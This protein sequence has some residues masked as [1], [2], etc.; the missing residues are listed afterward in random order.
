[1]SVTNEGAFSGTKI[2]INLTPKEIKALVK[3]ESSILNAARNYLI[4][5]GFTEVIVPHITKATGACENPNS[6]FEVDYFNEKIKPY[7][8]QTGQ[9]YLEIVVPILEKVWCCGS[10][11]RK[12]DKVDNRHLTEFTLLEFEFCGNFNQL[13]SKIEDLIK[14]MVNEALCYREE[15]EILKGNYR[16]LEMIKTPFE[17]LTYSEAI[18]IL[19]LNWGDD[20]NSKNEKYLIE[21][22]GNKP[23]FIT[24][25][26]N[27]IKFFNMKRNSD[28][29]QVVN[30]ADL[31]LPFS[32]EAVGAA[33]REIDYVI[34]KEKLEQS[35]MFKQ[36]TAMGRQIEDFEWYLNFF[37][38]NQSCPHAGCG[39][40]VERVIQFILASN[41]I[42]QSTL[43]PLNRINL[44]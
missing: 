26:P 34:L 3:I 9:L 13:L 11:F 1:M 22:F 27:D 44:L 29:P 32:G 7:L 25:F 41:D 16:N 14:A 43:F 19:N 33:E 42:R 18:E 31:L 30:S 2:P 28:N 4:D 17:K 24:H 15:L 23:I 20:F 35:S 38:E 21:K 6:L 36:L 8:S 10:S 12:E 40:G 5:D 39:I 37:K